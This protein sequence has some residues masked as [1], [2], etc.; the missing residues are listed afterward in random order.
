MIDFGAKEKLIYVAHPYGGLK[1]NADEAEKI[2]RQLYKDYRGRTFISPIHGICC[3]YES[4]SFEVGMEHCF[5]LLNRCDA[6]L[7]TGDWW[8]SRG[9]K[10]EKS[11]AEDMAI[12][13]YTL[14]ILNIV[15]GR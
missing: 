14:P 1:I 2:I 4:V 6:I 7:L 5:E 11:F 10:E 15:K 9:C 8:N 13:I 3:P 12:P